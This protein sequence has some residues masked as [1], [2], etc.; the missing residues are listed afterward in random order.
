ME[1]E[2]NFKARIKKEGKNKEVKNIDKDRD[3]KSRG[4]GNRDDGTYKREERSRSNQLAREGVNSKDF[5]P[6]MT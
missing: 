1:R 3:A 4:D 6:I 2:E 5:V